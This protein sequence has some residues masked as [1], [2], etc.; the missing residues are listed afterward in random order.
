MRRRDL[1]DHWQLKQRDPAKTLQDD[2]AASE[3]WLPATVPG[4]V[5]GD[6]LAQGLIPD[7]FQGLN[8]TAVQW[9]GEHDWIYRCRFTWAPDE[10]AD[11]EPVLCFGG[12]DTI[13][14]A[15]LNGQQIL[16]SDNMFVAHRGPI[17]AHLRA[18][19][20]KLIILFE[21]ALRV[22][23]ERE[24]E[25]G[26]MPCWNGD[27]SRVYVR[28]AQYHYGWDWGPRLLTAGPWQPVWLEHV[29]AR[30][31]ELHCPVEISD[32]L[33]S[34]RFPVR[35]AVEQPK[36]M[37]SAT[38]QL[39]LY[40]PGSELLSEHTFPSL[41]ETLRHTFAV[42]QP[43]LWW[44]HGYG[45]QARYRLVATLRQGDAVV[46]RQEQQLGV[47]RLRL[48]QDE[49]AD[50]E[51]KSFRFEV[52][53]TPI[54]CGGA[55]WIPAD[56]ILNR[57]SAERYRT[58]LQQAVDAHMQMIRVWGGGVY[59][60][61]TFY[62]LC[63]ELGL[64][65]W[66][67]FLFACALYP[68]HDAFL[69]SVRAETEAAVRRLRH[70]PCIALWC[71]NNEDYDVARSQDRPISGPIIDAFP[72]RA[73]YEQL[74]A[75]VCARLDPARPYWRGSP[76]GGADNNNELHE[77]DQ[78]VWSVWHGEQAPYQDYPRF[79][80]R[81][82]SEFGM[83]AQP[84]ATTLAAMASPAERYPG[85]RVLDFHFKAD[86]G[87]RRVAAYLSENLRVPS[88]MALYT[89]A[90]QV[91]QA[92]AIAAAYRGWRRQFQGPGRYGCSGALV[93]Q[94]N[95]C[96]PC[97]S[98]SIVD[99]ALIPKLAYYAARR[100][101][102]PLAL[103]LDHDSETTSALWAANSTS[104]EIQGIV[105]VRRWSLDGQL[106][107]D[108]ERTVT[109][110]P[111]RTTPLGSIA[112]TTDPTHSLQA[113][114]LVE[115]TVRARASLWPEPLKYLT[116]ADPELAVEHL[117]EGQLRLIA[118]APAKAVW[119]EAKGPVNWSD[120]G[121]DLFPDEPYTIQAANLSGQPLSMRSLFDL[122]PTP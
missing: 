71:G 100:A 88:D 15:W 66:Q 19:E 32:D 67:D 96:W 105:Q 56:L 57:V 75:E 34:A 69:Q 106:E 52:N 70:H 3:G 25:Y 36:K 73:I 18:G 74:L 58:L 107:G 98:W 59:E 94:L 81:F 115:G 72:A 39:A 10:A 117:P 78:H 90:T 121:F 44:P 65:V 84:S 2:C 113:H 51:G 120:N 62:D 119:L 108:A 43:E 76:Y 104:D 40:A 89:Y 4:V 103:E 82:V 11:G 22:G 61:D 21:S 27:S 46:E 33:R 16:T 122:Q 7:P 112:L 5:Q 97:I 99:D 60:S 92:E 1:A 17:Q 20:N 9:V 116:L 14:T 93:W 41:E 45:E 12:L 26:K 114:L 54:F 87:V 29:S 77:G 53:N 95:D 83:A 86:G 110:A 55:N 101:L 42:E 111:H 30:I 28:K 91:M 118:R 50:E 47:R 63:D 79:T 13:A 102:A 64:L 23:R 85:S 68:A 8:E 37:P 109:L 49:V 24:A 35:V 6:L 38:L 80:G 48:L 31:A